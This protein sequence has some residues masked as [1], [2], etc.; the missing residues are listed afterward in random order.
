MNFSL[1]AVTISANLQS[2]P[3]NYRKT[4]VNR[5][6]KIQLDHTQNIPVT[7]LPSHIG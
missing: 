4:L 5:I 1:P 7:T 2:D 6:K 3:R